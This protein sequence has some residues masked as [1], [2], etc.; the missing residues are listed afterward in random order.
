MNYK[1]IKNYEKFNKKILKN[2]FFFF[3][4]LVRILRSEYNRTIF[5]LIFIISPA[6][7]I[8]I[9]DG[10]SFGS[11]DIEFLRSPHFARPVLTQYAPTDKNRMV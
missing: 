1:T 7:Q 11:R 4:D 10:V 2:V 9:I 8:K 3:F 5:V 6:S